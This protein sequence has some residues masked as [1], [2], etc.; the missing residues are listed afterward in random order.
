M[1][2]HSFFSLPPPR[3]NYWLSP[4]EV[5]ASIFSGY[6]DFPHPLPRVS[7]LTVSSSV[8]SRAA[9]VLTRPACALHLSANSSEPEHTFNAKCRRGAD[10]Q[11]LKYPADWVSQCSSNLTKVPEGSGLS[12]LPQFHL[13]SERKAL[14]GG[15]LIPWMRRII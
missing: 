11:L 8:T 10:Y 4:G 1:S 2:Q 13:S 9:L 15:F 14:Y 3:P 5:R 7:Q 6:Q 12:F